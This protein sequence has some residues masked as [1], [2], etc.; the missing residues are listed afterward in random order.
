MQ[1]LRQLP[2]DDP[3]RTEAKAEESCDE[4]ADAEVALDDRDRALVGPVGVLGGV[5]AI[6]V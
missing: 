3:A 4:Q 6:V 2:I 1:R 5:L